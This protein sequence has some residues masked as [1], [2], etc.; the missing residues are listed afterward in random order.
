MS[1]VLSQTHTAATNLANNP[2][3][4][5]VLGFLPVKFV[6]NTLIPL[7]SVQPPASMSAP[8]ALALEQTTLTDINNTSLY[9]NLYLNSISS[10]FG[11]P[12][13]DS[14][15]LAA[16]SK[17][18]VAD[19]AAFYPSPY[20]FVGPSSVSW[21]KA[22]SNGN[23]SSINGPPPSGQF[24]DIGFA[25]P[26]VLEQIPQAGSVDLGVGNSVGTL[27]FQ[28]GP[29]TV[30][31]TAD[32][33]DAVNVYGTVSAVGAMNLSTLTVSGK[34]SEAPDS[35]IIA[36]HVTLLS[37]SYGEVL[38][39]ADV[40]FLA[41]TGTLAVEDG[42]PFSFSVQGFTAG[43]V[44]DFPGQSNLTVSTDDVDT[45]S[46]QAT[47]W[48]GKTPLYTINFDSGTNIAELETLD[49]ESG[50]TKLLLDSAPQVTNPDPQLQGSNVDWS[51]VHL[52][53]APGGIDVY[54][55][56]VPT[57]GV[58]GVTIGLGVDLD[59]VGWAPADFDAVLA[60]GGETVSSN[61]A[62]RVLE[63][64]VIPPTIANNDD[65]NDNATLYLQSV[66]E[67]QYAQ[68]ISG[69]QSAALSIT[70]QQAQ[71]LD[72]AAEIKILTAVEN[73]WSNANTGLAFSALPQ[74]VQTVIA[75]L[76]FNTGPNFPLTKAGGA[77][78]RDILPAAATISGPNDIGDVNAWAKVAEDLFH[79]SR[80]PSRGIADARE[81]LTMPGVA[82]AVLSPVVPTPI[83]DPAFLFSAAPGTQY[84]LV[85]TGSETYTLT[86]LPGSPDM[87]S[88]TLPGPSDDVASYS[89][90]FL[91]GTTSTL[92]T[93]EAD[94]I[95]D[96]PAGTT[97]IVISLL[98]ASGNV[99]TYPSDFAFYLTYATNGTVN[100]NVTG[101]VPP[102]PATYTA[103]TLP[104]GGPGPLPCFV[105][106]TLIR[107]GRGS[108]AVENLRRGDLV[109][110][111]VGGELKA[112]VW[113]G[114]RTTQCMHHPM[115]RAV[116]PVCVHANAFADGQPVRDLFL[117]PDHAV[118]INNVLIPV[119]LLINGTTV[120]QRPVDTI[121]YYHVE[122]SSH[123][124]LLA[125]DLTVESYL[126]VGDRWN[127]EN[128]GSTTALFPDFGSRRLGVA[129]CWE[130]YACAPLV[131][132]GPALHAARALLSARAVKAMP[133]WVR[134]DWRTHAWCAP[135]VE[136]VEPDARLVATGR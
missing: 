8:T 95:V 128:G 49:D 45:P 125:E 28:N 98:D 78:W 57:Q 40:T 119:K 67:I 90:T 41:S 134:S 115:P 86:S 6:Q 12:L 87:S 62:L 96:V 48:D 9:M 83:T 103:P 50:G 135:G 74:P 56:Y 130:A 47:I 27:T 31:G 120:T 30:S 68:G 24:G 118:F 136:P 105:A 38:S 46:T 84:A 113:I 65:R 23:L 111:V 108:V 72:Q 43:N 122:L 5:N 101:N 73:N 59:N 126:D 124:V 133:A 3:V 127:F 4:N 26:S 17:Q 37:G 29:W 63:A 20:I 93:A 110:T 51:L 75:D 104:A 106:G 1:D 53:E 42:A 77:V 88:L 60:A 71:L 112:V 44:I 91:Q 114:H 69:P 109:P 89:I 131:Q 11:D 36:N 107:T 121:T 99:L 7:E 80:N 52:S 22:D 21:A 97:S 61:P 55:P 66:G 34:L 100:V 123:D 102:V 39:L 92:A 35:A 10:G 117:S 81:L 129:L 70:P 19:L 15:Q 25:P 18:V 76:G 58:S 64:A 132:S 79:Y 16:D 13:F 33:L 2:R 14:A 54:A 94:A 82:A 32:T 116:W 85:V